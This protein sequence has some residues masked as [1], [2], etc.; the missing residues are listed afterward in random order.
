MDEKVKSGRK[1]RALGNSTENY[2]AGGFLVVKKC[3]GLSAIQTVA[4][5]MNNTSGKRCVMN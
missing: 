4:Q 5:P 2:F 1:N 3:A